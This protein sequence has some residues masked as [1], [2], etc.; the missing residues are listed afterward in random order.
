MVHH[1][2]WNAQ[3]S[4]PVVFYSVVDKRIFW[5]DWRSQDYEIVKADDARLL[6]V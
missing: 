4:L 5:T 2:G 3:V 1:S 6:K